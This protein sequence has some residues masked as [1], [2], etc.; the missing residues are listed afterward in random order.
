MPA[1]L[2]RGPR[3]G[4]P[5]DERLTELWGVVSIEKIAN[6]LGRTPCSIAK[7][8]LRNRLGP[9]LANVITLRQLELETGYNRTR[10]RGAAARLKIRLRRSKRMSEKAPRVKSG[11][12]RR[13]IVTTEQREAIIAYLATVPD[14][15]HIWSNTKKKT[16]RDAW[17]TGGKPAA[18]AKC[19]K[20]DKPHKA[21]GVCV[22]CYRG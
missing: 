21:K 4:R 17:G 1:A 19:G 8:A 11:K 14:G 18:C 2:T 9:A 16:S 6:E 20:T 12:Y 13:I 22:R 15:R 5:D 10:L 7:R 3:W